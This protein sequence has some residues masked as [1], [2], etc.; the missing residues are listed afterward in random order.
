MKRP[1]K[2]EYPES[3][4]LGRSEV[5]GYNK[6]CDDHDKFLPALITQSPKDWG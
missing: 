2:R 5:F 4:M 6:A 3:D 1:E